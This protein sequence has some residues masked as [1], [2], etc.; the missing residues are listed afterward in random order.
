M[1][2]LGRVVFLKRL[3]EELLEK[4]KQEPLSINLTKLTSKYGGSI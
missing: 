4:R 1:G 3:R 2:L